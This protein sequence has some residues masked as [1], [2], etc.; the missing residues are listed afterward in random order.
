[1]VIRLQPKRNSGSLIADVVVA[2]GLIVITLLP[3]SFSFLRE[4]RLLHRDYEHA[5]A[6]EI[7]DGEMEVLAAGE[8]R[9]FA[10]GEQDYPVRSA[11]AKN[12]ASGRFIFSRTGN[13][14]KLEWRGKNKT[15]HVTRE[16]MGQ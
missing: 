12:L 14:L 4:Q 9:E 6:M 10:E 2:M 13:N 8:W 7:V 5:V 15:G 3:I 1:V 11:A 16:A